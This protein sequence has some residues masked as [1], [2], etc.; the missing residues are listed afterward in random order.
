[1]L[2]DHTGLH[3]TYQLGRTGVVPL[4]ERLANIEAR[5]AA[6]EAQ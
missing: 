4:M 6:L 3:L 1:M 5:L 2:A